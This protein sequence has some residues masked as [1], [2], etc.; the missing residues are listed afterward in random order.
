MRLTTTSQSIQSVV[1]AGGKAADS[2]TNSGTTLLS[3]VYHPKRRCRDFDGNI[4]ILFYLFVVMVKN[5][6]FLIP[7]PCSSPLYITI[8]CVKVERMPFTL[9]LLWVSS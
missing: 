7:Y 5:L 3:G 9:I 6:I 1:S 2:T 8:F 4:N